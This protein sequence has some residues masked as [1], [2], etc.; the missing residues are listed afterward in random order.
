V[1]EGDAGRVQLAGELFQQ[2]DQLHGESRFSS[3]PR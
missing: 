3:T 2:C 1:A